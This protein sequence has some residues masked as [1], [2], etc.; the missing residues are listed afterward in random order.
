MKNKLCVLQLKVTKC[1]CVWQTNMHRNIKWKVEQRQVTSMMKAVINAC[2]NS[3]SLLWKKQVK[4]IFIWHQIWEICLQVNF[5]WQE[6]CRKMVRG[7]IIIPNMLKKCMVGNLE[8]TK[9]M[10]IILA[11]ERNEKILNSWKLTR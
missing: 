9:T 6:L 11:M 7:K 5:L 2:F 3:K 1:T 8:T 10:I 4:E